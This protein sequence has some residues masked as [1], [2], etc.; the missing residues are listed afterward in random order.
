MKNKLIFGL[1]FMGSVSL[2]ACKDNCVVCSG[3][4]A[5]QKV[6][7]DDYAEKSDYE[8]FVSEYEELEGGVCN[9]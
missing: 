1:I 4:T 9:E 7:Q 2:N 8:R 6:C 3:P 5:P